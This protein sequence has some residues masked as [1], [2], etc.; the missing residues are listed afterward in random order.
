MIVELTPVGRELTLR[1]TEPVSP[2]GRETETLMTEG[3]PSCGASAMLELRLRLRE[4][5]VPVEPE[6]PHPAARK[7]APN[8]ARHRA[9]K[10]GEKSS[11]KAE[12]PF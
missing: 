12:S 11:F 1:V 4:P 10:R 8:D 3:V 9:K 6:P 2:E 7:T 5:P